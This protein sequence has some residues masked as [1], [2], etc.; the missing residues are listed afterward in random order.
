M[1]SLFSV[2]TVAFLACFALASPPIKSA[3][4]AAAGP[5][6]PAPSPAPSP[7][8]SPGPADCATCAKC[9]GACGTQYAE[10]QRKCFAQPDLPSQ[11]ACGA[12]CPSVVECAKNCPCSGCT[13]PGLPGH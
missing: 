13:V 1:R 7:S 2:A 5:P 3:A 11:Q 9:V 6:A 10:C 12:Q 8:P 4:A